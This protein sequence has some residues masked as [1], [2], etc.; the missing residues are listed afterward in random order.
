MGVTGLRRGMT[1]CKKY[2]FLGEKNWENFQNLGTADALMFEN[3][4]F[5]QKISFFWEKWL[6][7][8]LKS[9]MYRWNSLKYLKNWQK[10]LI[11]GHFYLFRKIPIF[12]KSKI[13]KSQ[14]PK[15]LPLCC[16]LDFNDTIYNTEFLALCPTPSISTKQQSLSHLNWV[17]TKFWGVSWNKSV[18]CY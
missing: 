11:S 8:T 6:F 10:A 2:L 12:R 5:F 4:H 1:F 3:W 17:G 9:S 15:S 14:Q 16:T 13:E 18:C 7:W